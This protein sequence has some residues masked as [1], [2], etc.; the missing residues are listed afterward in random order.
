MLKRLMEPLLRIP[1]RAQPQ[2]VPTP[3]AGELGLFTVDATWGT[4]TPIQLAPD[5]RTVGELEVIEHIAAGRPL[6]DTRLPH[7]FASGTIPGAL[8]IPHGE[9]ISRIEQLDPEQSTVFFCNGPQC[10]A[11]PRA[12]SALLAA[13]YPPTA[14]LY[15]RGGMHDWLTL[16]LPHEL[17]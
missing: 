13:N 3:V 11:T 1:R 8:S 10:P 2:M 15:Y 4:V 5:V 17:P 14:I 6:V 16:G 12:V 9:E 7:F